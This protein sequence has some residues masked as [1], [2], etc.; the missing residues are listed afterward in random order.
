MARV[1]KLPN[2]SLA[3]ENPSAPNG[4]VVL[5]KELEGEVT[6]HNVQQ[7][8]GVTTGERLLLKNLT[9]PERIRPTLEEWGYETRPLDTHGSNFA[10]RKRGSNDPWRVL[11][12]DTGIF[13]RDFANDV[14]DVLYDGFQALVT[15]ASFVP[16]GFVGAAAAGAGSELLREGLGA[17]AGVK[18]NFSAGEVGLQGAVGG[19]GF[20]VGKAVGA[21]AGFVAGKVAPKASSFLYE[22]GARA[23]GVKPLKEAGL[24]AGE[25]LDIVAERATQGIKNTPS[26]ESV[27]LQ[28]LRI[29]HKL[30]KMPGGGPPAAKIARFMPSARRARQLEQM[31][32]SS[33]ATV[34]LRS[35]V[36]P[37]QMATLEEKGA[38]EITK[39]TAGRTSSTVGTEFSGER[40]GLITNRLKN[41]ETAYDIAQ[42]GS[43]QRETARTFE[44]VRTLFGKRMGARSAKAAEKML[45]E[46]SLP[47]EATETLD[48]IINRIADMQGID[49]KDVDLAMVPVSVASRVK[50]ALQTRADAYGAFTRSGQGQFDEVGKLHVNV[51]GAV[52]QAIEDKMDSLGGAFRGYV[53]MMAETD[54]VVH[55]M[56]NFFTAIG[57]EQ[58]HVI[59]KITQKGGKRI[60]ITQP[61]FSVA[62]RA[63][64]TQVVRTL[65]GNGSAAI[66]AV[67]D[68]E[69]TT[70]IATGLEDTAL[71]AQIGEAFA[72][73]GSEGVPGQ[74]ARLTATGV[75]IG[76][77]L[78]GGALGG[79]AGGV[80][81]AIAGGAA[82]AFLASPKAILAYATNAK[83]VS[84]LLGK[85][86]GAA[87]RASVAASRLAAVAALQQAAKAQSGGSKAVASESTPTKRKAY[88]TGS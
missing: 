52:R 27:G 34:D 53:P 35:A 12:P 7:E 76:G 9:R 8:M 85:P 78:L 77:A 19:V 73:V 4:Y 63:K 41:K 33:G 59:R 28:M 30:D 58:P 69:R 82:G 39:R 13:S 66:E 10:V 16:G 75:P 67:R 72:G 55:S 70:K 54:R 88:F 86:V 6:P 49:P 45:G 3:A 87:G 14:S 83:R 64:A 62:A 18:D 47:K 25:V 43:T 23:A 68:I 44:N 57:Y 24:A 15:G 60:I 26:P 21:A 65:H 2:G 38:Q 40:S 79:S 81:G 46:P 51:S 84:N 56:H 71:M 74:F 5:P 32:D 42:E 17:A 80:P 11:D 20:G 50:R 31:A 22:M 29:A 48:T 1:F 37:L 61:K 36:K